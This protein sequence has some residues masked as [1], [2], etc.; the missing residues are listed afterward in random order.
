MFFVVCCLYKLR[1]NNV[2]SR[3]RLT[4]SGLLFVYPYFFLIGLIFFANLNIP[5][6]L[7]FVGEL[8][9]LVSAVQLGFSTL[10]FLLVGSFLLLIP[11]LMIIALFLMCTL[12]PSEFIWYYRCL[13]K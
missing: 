4:Y 12:K 11:I 1:L 7:G 3:N 10:F 5:L 9:V 2:L 8:V 6:T 13:G